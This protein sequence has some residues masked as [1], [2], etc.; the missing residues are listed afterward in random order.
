[1]SLNI[2]VVQLV[3]VAHIASIYTGGSTNENFKR[4]KSRAIGPEV[5]LDF[6]L[7]ERCKKLKREGKR[8]QT[9]LFPV[10]LNGAPRLRL[11]LISLSAWSC[12]RIG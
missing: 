3:K 4:G 6:V 11:F 7:P 5:K 12:S 8:G 9:S 10:P 2:R 1:M